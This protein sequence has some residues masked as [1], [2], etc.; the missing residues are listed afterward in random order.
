M[1]YPP[2]GM[3]LK[4]TLSG[5]VKIVGGAVASA[6]DAASNAAGTTFAAAKNSAEKAGHSA[7]EF[8][9]LN[10]HDYRRHS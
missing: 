10:R 8:G 2:L 7:I 3:K 4:S 6:A 1:D 5:F 9:K